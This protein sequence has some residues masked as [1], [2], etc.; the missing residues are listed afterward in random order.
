M[1]I[2]IRNYRRDHYYGPH[3]MGLGYGVLLHRGSEMALYFIVIN[4]RV[5]NESGFHRLLASWLVHPQQLLQVTII[6]TIIMIDIMNHDQES[7]GFV[8]GDV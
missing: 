2:Q 3:I 1:Y 6:V 4:V 5:K 8:Q 7:G